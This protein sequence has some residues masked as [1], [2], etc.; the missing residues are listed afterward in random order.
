[1][2]INDAFIAKYTDPKTWASETIAA[3]NAKLVELETEES[4]DEDDHEES[5]HDNDDI[6]GRA[7]ISVA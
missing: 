6:N 2:N 7:V 5:D 1:M 4:E 3:Y